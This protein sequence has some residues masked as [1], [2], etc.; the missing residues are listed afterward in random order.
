MF[1][2]YKSYARVDEHT[3]SKC[4]FKLA[5]LNGFYD[6]PCTVVVSQLCIASGEASLQASAECYDVSVELH[7]SS[8]VSAYLRVRPPP[9]Q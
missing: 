1:Y 3:M 2:S 6:P 4:A 7:G 8:I 5:A 9:E